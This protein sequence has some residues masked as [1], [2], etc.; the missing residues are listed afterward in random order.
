MAQGPS[1]SWG[2]WGARD[3]GTVP[4]QALQN[5]LTYSNRGTWSEIL[6]MVCLLL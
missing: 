3:M 1:M 2:N 4:R 6:G 5:N